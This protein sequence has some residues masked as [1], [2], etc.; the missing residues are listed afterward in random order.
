[1]ENWASWYDFEVDDELREFDWP[2][3]YARGLLLARLFAALVKDSGI[4]VIFRCARDS[5][6]ELHEV[7]LVAGRQLDT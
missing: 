7:I 5:S 1:L 6:R 4:P 2:A 3:F